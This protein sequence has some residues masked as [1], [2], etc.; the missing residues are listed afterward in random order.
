MK[1]ILLGFTVTLLL[2]VS[3]AI[4]DPAADNSQRRFSIA[5]SGGA[6]KGAYEAGLNWGLLKILRDIK[7]IDSALF[8]KFSDFEAA[9]FAGASAGGINT[10][11]SSLTWC[12]RPESEGGLENSI[13]ANIFRDV[14]L[15]LDVNRLL[16]PTAD[17]SYYDSSDALLSRYDLLQASKKL[18]QYWA[19]PIFRKGCR[20]P[21]GVTVTRIKPDTLITGNVKVNNQRMIIPF[22]AYTKSDGT[23]G[24]SFNPNDYSVLSDPAMILMPSLKNARPY[25]ID[26][27]RIEDAA[28]ASSAFPAGFGRKR[29]Q[30]CRLNSFTVA[31]NDNAEGKNKPDA[32]LVCPEDYELTEAEF[33]DGGLFDNLPLGLARK[34]AE[35]QTTANKNTA[36]VTYIYLDPDRVRYPVPVEKTKKA[37]DSDQPPKACDTMEYSFFTEQSLLSN[38]LGTARNYELYRELISTEWNL[39][40]EQLSYQVAKK[41]EL[42]QHSHDCKFNI[43]LFIK[44]MSCAESVRRAGALL[45]MSYNRVYVSIPPPYSIAKLRK[46]GIAYECGSINKD[47]STNQQSECKIN[48]SLYRQRLAKILI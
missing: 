46:L 9:S 41:F 29:L 40:L 24:F 10:L 21:L 2:F 15:A 35:Q 5:I 17:S 4:A 22:V 38:A 32:N 13:D 26:Y 25:S 44:K 37:C 30:Y 1:K 42:D 7:H 3:G 39:N 45:E 47:N 20:I 43:P 8:G 33:A 19:K 16:P 18:R 36:R 31:R 48:L 6:S 27:Q 28:L 11:L 14:W 23:L 34:L 12:G